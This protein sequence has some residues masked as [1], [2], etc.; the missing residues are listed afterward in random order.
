M[1]A[2]FISI[3]FLC[4]I[5]MIVGFFSPKSSLFWMKDQGKRTRMISFLIYFPAFIILGS[6][7]SLFEDGDS[8]NENSTT[9]EI[10]QENDELEKKEA[11]S[12]WYYSKDYDEMNE[13][14]IYFATCTSLNSH[15]FEFPYNGGSELYLIIRNMGEG[16]EVLLRISKGSIYGSLNNEIIRFKFDDGKPES[17]SFNSASDGSSELAFLNQPNKLLNKI[18]KSKKVKIDIPIFQEGRPV[19][20]FNV[21]G[22]KWEH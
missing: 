1:G 14:T 18:L 13:R 19:F 7:S 6:L 4:F 9:Q 5:F 12:N 2:L 17:Y 10:K 11:P 20:D 22:L 16:N 15:E 21:E 3:S 8:T